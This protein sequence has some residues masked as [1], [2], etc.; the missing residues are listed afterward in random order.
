MEQKA[1]KRNIRRIA[2]VGMVLVIAAALLLGSAPAQAAGGLVM[3]TDYPGVTAKAGEEVAFPLELDSTT[4]ASLNTALSVASLPEGWTGYFEG[5]GSQIS[6]VFVKGNDAGGESAAA[7]FHL[8]IPED[9][10]EGT[11]DVLL[12]G[13]AG[14][15]AADTL[16]LQINVSAEEVAQGQFVSQYSELQGP[17]S[18]TFNFSAT[19]SNNSGSEQAYSL[20]AQAPEGWQVTFAPSG[21]SSQIA[22]LTLG[23]GES[24][25]LDISVTPA[26]NVTAGEY[27]I[28]CIA[29][30]GGETLTAELKVIIT[31]TYGLQVSTPSG[32]LS[33]DSYAGS[34]TA[35]TL[36]ITNTS[37]A[38]LQNV[39]LTSTAPDG[40]SVRFDSAA[41]DSI[42]AG[43]TREVTAY[44]TSSTDALSGDYVTQITATANETTASAEFRVAVKTQTVWGIVGAVIIVILAYAVYRIFRKYGRR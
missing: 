24:Q 26:A 38:E 10:P 1:E 41:I 37:S 12:T 2:A 39:A 40:W 34:E 25:G 8:T 11:Y 32:N 7:T 23:A 31:G 20:A 35:V 13:D 6:R 44:I 21:E 14:S 36:S 15:G 5:N 18:A 43:E 4:G 17:A 3:S 16:Q 27:T 22:S 33:V 29:A 9:T 30:S 19:L 28:P 42:P